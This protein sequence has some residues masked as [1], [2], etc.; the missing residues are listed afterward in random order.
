MRET[1]F[2]ITTISA[3]LV[4]S[5]ST[6]NSDQVVWKMDPQLSS[7]IW[8]R[9]ITGRVDGCS[10]ISSIHFSTAMNLTAKSETSMVNVGFK[11]ITDGDILHAPKKNR[12]KL[13]S[14]LHGIPYFFV[15]DSIGVF[16]QPKKCNYIT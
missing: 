8:T 9:F 1:V 4:S 2:S 13:T 14:G 10:K 12:N 3:N 11:E 7:W 15:K 16:V 5:L 6:I